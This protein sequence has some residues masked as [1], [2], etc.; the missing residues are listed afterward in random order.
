MAQVDFLSEAKA[1]GEGNGKWER[2]EGQCGK[3]NTAGFTS[4]EVAKGLNQETGE[5]FMTV[6]FHFTNSDGQPDRKFLKPS[7]TML[8][9]IHV[10]QNVPLDNIQALTL[11]HKEDGRICR[12]IQW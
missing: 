9:S 6:C 1:Y 10:G 8:D 7:V 2:V 11:K 4:A 12:C 5:T 3:L